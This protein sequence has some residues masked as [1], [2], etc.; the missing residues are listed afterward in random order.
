M[1]GAY[2]DFVIELKSTCLPEH[3]ALQPLTFEQF[4]ALLDPTNSDARQTKI[5]RPLVAIFIDK[6]IM[7]P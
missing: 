7:W 4:L 1:P 5:T 2:P 3:V 6:S